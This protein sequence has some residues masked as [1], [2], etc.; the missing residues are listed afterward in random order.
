MGISVLAITDHNNVDGLSAFREASKEYA[1]TIFPGFE[2]SS[3]E[4][5]HV[6]CIYPPESE[7]AQLGRYLGHFGIQGLQSS[8]ELSTKSFVDIIKDVHEQG[9]IPIAAHITN[10]SGLFKKLSGQSR[11][12]AWKDPNLLAVQIPGPVASLERNE[13]QIIENKNPDYHRSRVVATINAKDIKDSNDLDD[14]S[15][16][17]WVKMSAV[18][19]EGLRQ[20][21]LDPESRIRLNSDHMQEEHIELV[22]LAWEGG[23]LGGISIFF[24]SN[25][26]VLVGGRGAGKSAIIESIRYVLG[27]KP[28]GEDAEKVHDGI[29][30]RVLRSGTKVSLRLR[31]HRPA[32]AEYSI[33]RVINN[34]PVVRDE[35]GQISNL[36]PSDIIPRVEVYG[37]HEISEL[38]GNPE[39]LTKV[40]DR[41]VSQERPVKEKKDSIKRELEENRSSLL[42]MGYKMND[43]DERL[44][45]LPSLEETLNRYQQ[46]GLEGRLSEKSLLVREER[47]I[48]SISKSIQPFRETLTSFR[49]NLPIERGFLSSEALEELPGREILR[50]ANDFLSQASEEFQSAAAQID[51]AIEQAEKE[52]RKL[53]ERWNL[54]KEEV[55]SNYQS[56]LRD[57]GQSAVDGE[58]FI[59]LR[60]E[61]ENL[62]PLREERYLLQEQV[63][64]LTEK[65]HSLL[66][67]WEDIKAEEFRQLDEAAKAVNRQ[68]RN[69]VQVEVSVSGNRDPLFEVL[70]EKIGGRFSETVEKIK[71]MPDFSLP[72]FIDTCRKGATEIQR[73][74]GIPQAQAAS[75]S[76]AANDVL[77]QMEG[78]ELLPTT[79]IR[80]N[81]A[82]PSATPLWQELDKLSTGQ[83]STAV[84]LL[85]LLES[86]APLIID[87]PEDDLDNRFITEGVVPKMR[88]GKRRRQFV[89]STHNANIP[90]LGDA[91]LILG[92]TASGAGD[93]SEGQAVIAPEHMGSIDA[94]PVRELVGQILEGGRDA[95][96]TRRLKYGF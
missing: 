18:S 70:R 75:L 73:S 54:R 10:D 38:T 6:L 77:M 11:M 87:Q 74:Y 30:K 83:K 68:L 35:S 48:A 78:L 21:F 40:L 32:K 28:I 7:E 34:P 2:L 45:K 69:Y 52:A 37:Q 50:D 93:I 67:D 95:F 61:I 90:V 86:E 94:A 29:V 5:I 62:L 85:L 46:A 49:Q 31:C 36:Q 66:V 65:R 58:D 8:S 27:L 25:L 43:L 20:A 81:I 14:P 41:F 89:F 53:Q 79:A 92:I 22:S 64:D 63:R 71:Q 9:G 47:V 4:G 96:E 1:I 13:R 33:E 44:A 16:T 3:S 82:P 60:R 24:N 56:I 19:V 88:E 23:F 76:G 51:H 84:L 80:L 72:S 17:C 91:E 15:A 57:L 55:E 12:R 42:Q 39:K 59:A 26:N